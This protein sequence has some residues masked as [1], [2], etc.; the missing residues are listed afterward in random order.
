MLKVTQL[1][2]H[3]Q[4][5]C[6]LEKRYRKVLYEFS[7][8]WWPS[9]FHCIVAVFCL[10]TVV[11]FYQISMES[12]HSLY[13]K[14]QSSCLKFS[15]YSFI[16]RVVFA[17]WKVRVV[18]RSVTQCHYCPHH[19]PLSLKKSANICICVFVLKGCCRLGLIRLLPCY[20]QYVV[21]IDTW[22]PGYVSCRAPWLYCHNDFI[23][24]SEIKWSQF[25]FFKL[26]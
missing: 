25:L 13:W 16:Y 7:F 5:F 11:G 22:L 10:V 15:T 12:R 8:I 20:I 14:Q 23:N 3:E 17:K 6:M 19:L 18:H 26:N 2:L 9:L 4:I 21:F 1:C 24:H